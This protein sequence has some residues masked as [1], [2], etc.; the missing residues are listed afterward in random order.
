MAVVFLEITLKNG[1]FD[2]TNGVNICEFRET[3]I[4]ANDW[5]C[6]IKKDGGIVC[7]VIEGN[8]ELRYAILKSGY[9]RM[10][11]QEGN[12]PMKIIKEGYVI[13]RG[14]SIGNGV[15]FLSD[16]YITEK[17]TFFRSESLHKFHLE[18]GIARI[19]KVDPNMQ[20]FIKNA[21]CKGGGYDTDEINSGVFSEVL[22]DGKANKTAEIWTDTQ[23]LSEKYPGCDVSE[24][25]EMI[26]IEDATWAIQHVRKWRDDKIKEYR[27]LYSRVDFNQLNIPKELKV[28]TI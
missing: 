1:L 16:G 26:E 2:K 18:Y 6:F 15:I 28:A 10:T 22:T 4:K 12:E 20:Y 25:E 13:N 11:Y 5:E 27:I 7:R 24:L 21:H 14:E 3:Y 8:K 9:S 17:H 23:K 19:K